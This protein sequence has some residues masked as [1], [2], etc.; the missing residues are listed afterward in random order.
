MTKL[1]SRMR[2]ILKRTKK[3][4]ITKKDKEGFSINYLSGDK[5]INLPKMTFSLFH[6]GISSID[7]IISNKIHNQY[8]LNPENNNNH[9]N[10]EK[11]INMIKTTEENNFN[12][13][14]KNTNMYP[15]AI[16]PMVNNE[17]QLTKNIN[18][19]NNY[20]YYNNINIKI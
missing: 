5:G 6:R 14:I 19:I 9:I 16:H 12:R 18:D 3:K 4:M 1:K 17:N 13:A 11:N 7:K 15:H 10:Q 2:T 8:I 20:G